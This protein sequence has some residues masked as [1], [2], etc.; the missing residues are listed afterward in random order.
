M[1][2]EA[3]SRFSFLQDVSR[4]KLNRLSSLHRLEICLGSENC[5]PPQTKER[6]ERARGEQTDLAITIQNNAD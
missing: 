4:I 2:F 3:S 1:G 6:E 5:W